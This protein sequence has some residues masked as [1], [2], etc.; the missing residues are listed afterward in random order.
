MTVNPAGLSVQAK[1]PA[2][3]APKEIYLIGE[4]M[5]LDQGIPLNLPEAGLSTGSKM[6]GRAAGRVLAPWIG[7]ALRASLRIAIKLTLRS[8]LV[9][10]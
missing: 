5:S 3:L 9:Q 4:P 8:S 1:P 6:S 10:S 2:H 7:P